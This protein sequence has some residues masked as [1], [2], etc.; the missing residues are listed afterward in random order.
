MGI[1][2]RIFR[3][4]GTFISGIR[5]FLGLV[6]FGFVLIS[7]AGLFSDNLQPIPDKGALYLAPGGFLV[8]QKTY[9]D[10]P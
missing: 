10:P 2:R 9:T 4:V 7:I 5:T 3:F 8:D 1:I 6:I